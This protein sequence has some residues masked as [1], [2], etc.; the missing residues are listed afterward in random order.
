MT[1]VKAEQGESAAAEAP[2]HLQIKIKSQDGDSVEFK[3]KPTTKL[4][5]VRYGSDQGRNKQKWQCTSVI[6]SSSVVVICIPPSGVGPV[7]TC[8]AAP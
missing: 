1:D 5:K 4:E 8:R 3:V 6:V 7:V 2:T